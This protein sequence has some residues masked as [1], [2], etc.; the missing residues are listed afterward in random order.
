ML[1][2]PSKQPRTKAEQQAALA[3]MMKFYG[4]REWRLDHLYFVQDESGTKVLYKRRPA[5]Q[6]FYENSHLLDVIPKARQ[7][8]MSTH[9]GLDLLDQCLFRKDTAGGIIDYKLE[10]AKKKLAKL[11]F[12]YVN[13]PEFI[14]SRV[15][16]TK[17]NE[18][19]L[20][21]SNGSSIVVGTTHRGG[22]LQ[23][24]HLSEFGPIAAEKP[25]VAMQIITGA[26]NTIAPG[27]KIKVESTAHG[28]NGKF[29][30]LVERAKAKRADGTPLTALDFK[31]HF[32][33][34]MYRDDYR[35]PSG[36]V[37]VT[38]EVQEYFAQLKQ[39]YGI[40]VDGDQM[41]WYQQKLN[42]L[43]W[44]AMKA[45]FPSHL[46]ECFMRSLEGA[47]FKREMAKARGENRIGHRVPYDPTRRVHTCWDKGINEKSDRNSICWFQHDGMRFRWIDYHENAGEGIQYY[48]RIIHEKRE[49]R[50][51][52]YGTH[53]G[54]HDLKN[55]DWGNEAKTMEAIAADLGV[56][57]QIVPRVSHKEDSIEQARRVLN[58]SWIDQEYCARLVEVLD[59]YRKK[60]NKVL[61]QWTNE[62]LHD[63][64]S[65]GADAFQT[66]AMG[67]QPDKPEREGRREK[68]GTRKGT[69]WSA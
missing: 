56:K 17:D 3:Q 51:F 61:A 48:A 54:P 66:G 46:D 23:Y 36:M 26:F 49:Q 5:Q 37:I 9:I 13:L 65:N 31:L 52:I 57:F 68:F 38:Q 47:F 69:H 24:L 19:E 28:S 62:P 15:A 64:Y 14:Q 45:E 11:R 30:E 58:N 53:F 22:A 6:E 34:W 21:F 35:V 59:N 29:Y 8:G 27:Q 4:D 44:D 39:K 1:D 43:G 16:L 40:A 20:R 60:W 18:D 10:D 33:G 2:T 50:K 25:E 32:F 12:A 67:M 63:V 41:A 42:L 55:R 7:L